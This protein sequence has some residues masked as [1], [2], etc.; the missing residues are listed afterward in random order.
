MFSVG[1]AV[2]LRYLRCGAS[3]GVIVYLSFLAFNARWKADLSTKITTTGLREI[4]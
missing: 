1:G 2:V 4:V 3:K